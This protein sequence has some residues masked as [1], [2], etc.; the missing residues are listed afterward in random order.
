M[1]RK[2]SGGFT[3]MKKQTAFLL[4]IIGS[5]LFAFAGCS[6]NDSFTQQSYQSGDSVIEQ[7]VID[8]S[9]REL[10]ISASE[11]DQIHIDYFDSDKEKLK[12]SLSDDHTLT[13]ELT[14][15]KN[16]TDYIGTKA[17][18]E[19]RKIE[20]KIPNDI[21]IGLSANTTNEDIHITSLSFT[22]SVSLDS[23]GG[24]VI[25]DRVNA[26]KSIHLTSKNGDI[27]GTVLG[28]L[29]DFSITCTIK[30]GDCN[31]PLSKE[32]GTKSFVADCNNGDIN[33]EFVK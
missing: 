24:N 28:A 26:G 1:S 4:I 7:I 17:S 22:E 6:G 19:Y 33:I 3:T 27:T 5:V 8:V 10:Q 14:I 25:C 21:V 11:D 32:D 18:I 2:N 15:D 13:V 9:D 20:V 30:K 16:W 31:L 12:I 23:N 29:D